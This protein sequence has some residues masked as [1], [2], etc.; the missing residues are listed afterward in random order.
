M[1]G[2]PGLEPG[3]KV[4]ETSM[5]TIDTIPLRISKEWRV[6]R[7]FR[8]LHSPLST[9]FIYFPDAICGNGNDGKTFLI[10][11]GSECFSCSWSLRNCVLCTRCIAKLYYLSA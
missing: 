11:S 9:R 1:A 2:V 8:T 5:L 3:P 6:E 4:L 10:Q 7:K